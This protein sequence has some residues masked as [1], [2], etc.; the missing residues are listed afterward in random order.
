[1][2]G[3]FTTRGKGRGRGGYTRGG[4]KFAKRDRS[5]ED[6]NAPP[7]PKKAKAEDSGPF[8]P[9]LRKDDDGNDFISVGVSVH[10]SRNS[11]LQ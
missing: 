6:D 5:D 8:V 9:V 4:G 7:A 11:N 1:M 10:R 3:R 2:T